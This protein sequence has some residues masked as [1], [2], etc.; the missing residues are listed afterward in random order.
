MNGNA[1]IATAGKHKNN[2]NNS[3]FT[4]NDFDP[5][6]FYGDDEDDE[7]N[8]DEAFYEESQDGKGSNR[9]D[10]MNQNSE[11]AA[12]KNYNTHK[13]QP[14]HPENPYNKHNNHCRK[15]QPRN[16]DESCNIQQ[17]P[18]NTSHATVSSVLP[19]G[20]A[21]SRNNFHQEMTQASNSHSSSNM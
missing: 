21:D 3:G 11:Y 10:Q 7:E 13:Q 15:N 5:S 1:T 9:N 17:Q 6:S 20:T 18:N 12:R 16:D 8:G 4:S 2:Q 19:R 14:F